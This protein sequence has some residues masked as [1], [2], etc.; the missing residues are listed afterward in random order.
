VGLEFSIWPTKLSST[1]IVAGGIVYR[2]YFVYY[3]IL[4]YGSLLVIFIGLAG[5]A[6]WSQ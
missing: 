4:S 6:I 1:Q 2:E 5:L 3:G